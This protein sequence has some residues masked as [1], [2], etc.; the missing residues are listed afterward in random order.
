MKEGK[1]EGEKQREPDFQEVRGYI[2]CLGFQG[3]APLI[4]E[5]GAQRMF[6]EVIFIE[7]PKKKA[8]GSLNPIS[9]F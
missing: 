1:I 6:W 9:Y 8:V 2:C 7:A 3:P 4:Q 5:L